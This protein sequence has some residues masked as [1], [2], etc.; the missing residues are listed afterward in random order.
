MTLI[1]TFFPRTIDKLKKEKSEIDGP[2]PIL[3]D[4]VELDVL[5]ALLFGN[6]NYKSSRHSDAKGGLAGSQVEFGCNQV[7]LVRDQESKDKLPP[8]LKHALVLTVFEA[9]VNIISSYK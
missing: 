1:E 7:I 8:L 6:E 9:K 3:L 4:G 2:K 5:F